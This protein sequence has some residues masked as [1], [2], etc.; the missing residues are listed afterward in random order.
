MRRLRGSCS[1]VSSTGCLQCALPSQLHASWAMP[2]EVH[3]FQP[4]HRG[5]IQLISRMIVQV[6]P[7]TSHFQEFPVQEGTI[8]MMAALGVSCVWCRSPCRPTNASLYLHQ[9]FPQISSTGWSCHAAFSYVQP[10]EVKP[11]ELLPS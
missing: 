8:A 4:K 6:C 2:V 10:W 5:I 1:E 3:M 9:Q 7:C 11:P